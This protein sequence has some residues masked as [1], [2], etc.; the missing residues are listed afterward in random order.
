MLFEHD[1]S[2]IIG[3]IAG[4]GLENMLPAWPEKKCPILTPMHKMHPT[5]KLS[6]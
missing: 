2:S 6:F 4:R 5:Y 1:H 3:N